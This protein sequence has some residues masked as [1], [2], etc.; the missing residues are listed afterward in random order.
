MYADVDYFFNFIFALLA[1][2]TRLIMLMVYEVQP[3]P[4]MDEI[5]HVPQVQAYC[6]YSF[7]TVSLSFSLISC[8]STVILMFLFSG[9]R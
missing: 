1:S 7:S 3:N 2:F 4:Y 9:I 6:N 8:L 5:F